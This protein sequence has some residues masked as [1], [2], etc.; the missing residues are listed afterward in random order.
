MT[1]LKL[2][3]TTFVR[4]A[5]VAV[6]AWMVKHNIMTEGEAAALQDP[7]TIA[8]FAAAI[9]V[10]ATGIYLRLRSKFKT[11]VA[12]TLR[13]GATNDDVNFAVKNATLGQI[14]STQPNK[15]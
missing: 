7:M 5:I 2:I 14:L 1:V 11:N 12:L 6:A 13:P 4:Y 15:K 8:A 3:L 10:T 9:I